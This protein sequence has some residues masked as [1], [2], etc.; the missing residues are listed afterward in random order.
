[1]DVFALEIFQ[2]YLYVI[3]DHNGSVAR[4]RIGSSKVNN[5]KSQHVSMTLKNW[6][7][8]VSVCKISACNWISKSPVCHDE[9]P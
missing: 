2:G 8:T 5:G 6:G 7:T 1:M 4:E 3:L 9:L